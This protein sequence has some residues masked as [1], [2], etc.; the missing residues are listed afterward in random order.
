[1]M[2]GA[3]FSNTFNKLATSIRKE[4]SANSTGANQQPI[5]EDKPENEALNEEKL[6]ERRS[7]SE[8]IKK[9]KNEEAVKS[10]NLI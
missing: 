1:M 8:M 5:A 6:I 10:L 7:Y 4:S 2:A 3:G 9:S